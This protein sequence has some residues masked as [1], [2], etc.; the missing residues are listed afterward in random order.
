MKSIK[1]KSDET[2]KLIVIDDEGN[3]M[4]KQCFY[5]DSST[6]IQYKRANGLITIMDLIPLMPQV[7]NR[8]ENPKTTL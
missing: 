1:V 6:E 5:F 4:F 8:N 2:F 7:E 3:E